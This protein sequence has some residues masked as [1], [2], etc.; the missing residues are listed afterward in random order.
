M[1]PERLQLQWISASEGREFAAK[2]KE[3]D[4]IVRARACAQGAAAS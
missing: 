1:A 2:I 4:E 3:M